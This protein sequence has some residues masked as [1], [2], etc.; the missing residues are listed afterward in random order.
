MKSRLA[1]VQSKLTGSVAGVNP[2]D[3]SVGIYILQCRLVAETDFCLTLDRDTN[4]RLLAVRYQ[5]QLA[6]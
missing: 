6:V 4:R 2:A 3:Y 5:H 1:A